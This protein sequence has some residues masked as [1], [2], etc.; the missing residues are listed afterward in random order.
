VWTSNDAGKDDKG[1]FEYPHP[2]DIDGVKIAWKDGGY[3]TGFLGYRVW[4]LTAQGTWCALLRPG[5]PPGDPNPP[6]IV[7][8]DDTGQLGDVNADST[9]YSRVSMRVYLDKTVPPGV[10]YTYSVSAVTTT[11]ESERS[12]SVTAMAMPRP[13]QPLSPPAYLK[14]SAPGPTHLDKKWIHLRWCKNNELEEVWRYWVYRSTGQA[15]A[16]GPFTLLAEIDP[17]CLDNGKRCE[18]TQVGSFVEPVEGSCTAGIGGTCEISDQTVSQPLPGSNYDTQVATYTYNYVVTAVRNLGAGNVLESG[19][20]IM[21][22]GWPNYCSDTSCVARYDPDNFQ[23]TPCGDETATL[24]APEALR[25]LP[26]DH[27]A[28]VC[29]NEDSVAL[30]APYRTIGQ[31]YALPSPTLPRSRAKSAQ[32]TGKTEGSCALRV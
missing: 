1:I 28:P 25:D 2:R 19:F 31:G 10:E 17:A 23:D 20:S 4:R 22:S 16:V 8:C 5:T 30:I 24:K 29:V 11:G 18:I 13:S 27:G 26:V 32:G 3:G 15:N 9:Q 12:P 14:A 6:G 7:V 21:N